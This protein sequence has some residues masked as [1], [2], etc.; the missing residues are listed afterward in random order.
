MKRVPGLLLFLQDLLL[1]LKP[2]EFSA[3]R[4]YP[5]KNTD[6][7]LFEETDPV[8]R[9]AATDRTPS[10]DLCS[11]RSSDCCRSNASVSTEELE[12]SAMQSRSCSNGDESL[13][14]ASSSPVDVLQLQDAEPK[15]FGASQKDEAY[16]TMSSFY[17]IK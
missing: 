12:L 7:P 16:V 1:S 5:M 3:L 6:K 11:T 9:P 17:Q 2:E 14:V 8:L 13:Q 10:I 4:I 15:V